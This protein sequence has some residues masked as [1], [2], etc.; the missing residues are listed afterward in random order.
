MYK[1]EG[2]GANLQC[3]GDRFGANLTFGHPAI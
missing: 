1:A 2:G 3:L